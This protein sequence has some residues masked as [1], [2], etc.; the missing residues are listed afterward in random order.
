MPLI[1]A[2][3]ACGESD[4][5]IEDIMFLLQVQ[6]GLRQTIIPDAVKQLLRLRNEKE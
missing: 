1:Q 3:S 6:E 4:I 5:S 2:I